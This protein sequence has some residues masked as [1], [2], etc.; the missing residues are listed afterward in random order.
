VEN[1]FVD[2]DNTYMLFP[3]WLL[4]QI[5]SYI[6]GI[7]NFKHSKSNGERRQNSQTTQIEPSKKFLIV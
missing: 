5:V 1:E 2:N 6:L 3:G 7:M 4:N